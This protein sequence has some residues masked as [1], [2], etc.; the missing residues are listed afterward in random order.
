[1][2][3]SRPSLKLALVDS[4]RLDGMHEKGATVTIF[5]ALSNLDCTI[6]PAEVK[7]RASGGAECRYDHAT[8]MP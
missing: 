6:D 5:L 7:R 1:M 3:F 4:V 8:G 2:N